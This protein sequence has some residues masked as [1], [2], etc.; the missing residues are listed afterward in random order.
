MRYDRTVGTTYVDSSHYARTLSTARRAQP[1]SRSRSP[2]HTVSFAH[3]AQ[4]GVERCASQRRGTEPLACGGASNRLQ[5][6]R[7]SDHYLC[8]VLNAYLN[9]YRL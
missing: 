4:L 3:V 9:E 8:N 2:L 6:Q 1:R 5:I 7:A